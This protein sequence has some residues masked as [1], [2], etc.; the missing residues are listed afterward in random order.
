MLARLKIRKPTL[1]L[2]LKKGSKS[3]VSQLQKPRRTRRGLAKMLILKLKKRKRFKS[4]ESRLGRRK[5]MKVQ[6]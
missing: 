3:K 5:T 2:G 6:N 1:R 4:N